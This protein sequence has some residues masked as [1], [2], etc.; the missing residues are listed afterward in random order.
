MIF[1]CFPKK[2]TSDKKEKALRIKILEINFKV[3][4]SFPIP[5]KK[6]VLSNSYRVTKRI[7]LRYYSNEA[8]YTN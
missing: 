1:N 6:S 4:R 8:F 3:K 7:A 5:L 2:Y